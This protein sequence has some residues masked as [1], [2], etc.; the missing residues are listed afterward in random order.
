MV[1]EL[2]AQV[3]PGSESEL[4]TPVESEI[5]LTDFYGILCTIHA[6]EALQD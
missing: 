3:R 1:V 4:R 6:E 5:K 2:F